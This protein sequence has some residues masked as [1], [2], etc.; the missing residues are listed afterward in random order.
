METKHK[1]HTKSKKSDPK[2]TKSKL[3]TINKKVLYTFTLP[4]QKLQN[5]TKTYRKR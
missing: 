5:T 1:K 4:L 2:T 3:K